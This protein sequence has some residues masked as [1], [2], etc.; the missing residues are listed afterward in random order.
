MSLS[1]SYDDVRKS[2]RTGDVMLFSGTGFISRMI[3][4]RS[5]SPWSHVGL[6]VKSEELDLALLWES[7]TLSNIPD[8]ES[9]QKRQGVQLV[10]LSERV[11]AYD[12]KVAVR[13]IIEPFNNAELAALTAFRSKMKGRPYEQD[14]IQLARAAID[15][16]GTENTPDLSS[17]FCTELVAATFME[18]G[19][20]GRETPSNEFDPGDFAATA[21]APLTF[22]GPEVLIA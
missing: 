6:V 19:R 1:L 10:P 2:F 13:H 17:V 14:T 21:K 22:L 18:A 4:F 3:Q 11:A 15:W 20:L 16:A 12:G 7:T 5:G 8:M 9:G